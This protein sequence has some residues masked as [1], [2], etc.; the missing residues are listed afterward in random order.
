M[1]EFRRF[2]FD[3]RREPFLRPFH[4]KGGSFNE[5]WL[6]HTTLFE[7]NNPSAPRYTGIGGN[8][9]LWSDS[10]VFGAHTETGGNLVMSLTAEK[11][12]R[13]LS[14]GL[15]QGTELADPIAAIQAILT[16]LHR[17]GCRVSGT[18]ELRRTFTL[19]AA[20]SL[21]LA[22]WKLYA[23][24][25][26][27]ASFGDLIPRAYA[28]AF[29]ARQQAVARVPLVTYNLPEQELLDLVEEGH[30]LL[31]IKIGQAGTQAEMVEKDLARLEW[32]H[33]LLRDR[34]SDQ[35]Q[36]GHLAYYLDANG[37]YR[38]KETL[39]ALVAGLE[40]IGAADQVILLEEPFPDDRDFDVRDLSLRIAADESLHSV[41][42][43]R[44]KIELGYGAL[45][46]KPAGKTLS[47]SILMAAEA[48]A[49]N[50]PCFVA[51]SACVPLLVDWNRNVAAH[52]P[53]FPG[54]ACGIL[55]SNGAQN[56]RN[57]ET[58]ISE[59]PCSGAP[60]LEP[61]RGMYRLDEDFY[62]R[63]GGVFHP[64]GYKGKLG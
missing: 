10:A 41:E 59:H 6:N 33:R 16:E 14:D 3:I 17:F 24:S 13:L 25:E 45:A 20:V 27:I 12:V 44:R 61:K 8:A 34:R 29:S 4:F 38:E 46:L 19:N 42:D 2:E 50:I 9:V 55:E 62:D 30:F 5:K 51:D 1:I 60:W 28:G 39:L 36:T 56:F 43:V 37:R 35:T 52:L 54:L 57:W 22:L 47:M 31:K 7:S 40:R 63:A 58:L 15:S 64:T 26:G 18:G 32:I 23:A 11:A 21:D 53:A 49:R 48:H